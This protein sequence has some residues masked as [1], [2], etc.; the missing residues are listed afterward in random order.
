MYKTLVRKPEAKR[1]LGIPR[2]RCKNNNK[3]DLREIRWKVVN[4][5]HL[6]QDTYQLLV[7]VNTVTKF[8]VP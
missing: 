6:V 1:P 5:M 7:L 2:R 4:W 3:I 8:R